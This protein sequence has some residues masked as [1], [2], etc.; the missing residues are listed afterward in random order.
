[1]TSLVASTQTQTQWGCVQDGRVGN[2]LQVS[3]SNAAKMQEA[4]ILGSRS[5]SKILRD[6]PL[7]GYLAHTKQRHPRTLQQVYA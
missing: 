1:M 5:A 4:L 6:Y 3:L 7:Q 2:S